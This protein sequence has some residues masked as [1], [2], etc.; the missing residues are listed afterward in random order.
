M[1]GDI[2]P[3]TLPR[4]WRREGNRSAFR[5]AASRRPSQQAAVRRRGT[6]CGQVEDRLRV[7]EARSVAQAGQD[8]F[9]LQV[10]VVGENLLNSLLTS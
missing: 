2:S 10:R 6:S 7:R 5:A 1:C 9:P 4:S 3:A 8:V